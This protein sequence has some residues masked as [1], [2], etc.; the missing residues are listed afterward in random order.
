MSTTDIFPEHPYPV[1]APDPYRERVLLTLATAD[2]QN[3]TAQELQLY[4]NRH[5]AEMM[6]GQLADAVIELYV[7]LRKEEHD[8]T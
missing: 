5:M 4:T 3:W 1:Y 8:C 7:Q 6:Y 2:L